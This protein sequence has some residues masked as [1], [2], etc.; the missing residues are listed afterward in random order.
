MA[1]RAHSTKYLTCG[2]EMSNID[3]RVVSDDGRVVM[4]T[5]CMSC[6]PDN[7]TLSI[8]Y[9]DGYRFTLNGKKVSIK[10]IKE[11]FGKGAD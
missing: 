11:L 3:F 10:A 4:Q 8:M 1:I 5:T 6:I 2:V 7:E 9:Q